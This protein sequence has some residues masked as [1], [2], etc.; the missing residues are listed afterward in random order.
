MYIGRTNKAKL[1]QVGDKYSY[2]ARVKKKK[3]DNTAMAWI[4]KED[5]KIYPLNST[6][7]STQRC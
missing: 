5:N 4:S 6:W 7:K 2:K 1:N 3:A